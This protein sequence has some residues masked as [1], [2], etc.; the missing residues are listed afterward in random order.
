MGTA[1]YAFTNASGR[2]TTKLVMTMAQQ[3]AKVVV[4]TTNVYSSTGDPISMIMTTSM[5]MQDNS[6][7]ST[8]KVTFAGKKAT[9]VSTAMGK[10]TSKTSTAPGS[11]TDKSM[12]WFA[13]KLP[14]PGTSLV[15]YG[16]DPMKGDWS[17][18]TTKY[19]GTR[20]VKLSKG[21]A[22][23]HVLTQTSD[24]ET[25]KIYFTAKGD[26]LRLEAGGIILSQ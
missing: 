21:T 26:L 24:N 18:T 23:A 1:T 25:M 2:L 6:M 7:K 15:Y 11:V 12:L 5:S 3:G 17:K 20:S 22:T 14:A 16:F 19:H 8:V 9:I 13:G 10:S 4:D